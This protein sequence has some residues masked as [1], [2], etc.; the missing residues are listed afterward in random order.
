[1]DALPT[2]ILIAIYFWIPISALVG[3]ICWLLWKVLR[4]GLRRG[5]NDEPAAEEV[6][7][8]GFFGLRDGLLWRSNRPHI[9]SK[10]PL[11]EEL[12]P[13]PYSWGWWFQPWLWLLIV[14]ICAVIGWPISCDPVLPPLTDPVRPPVSAPPSR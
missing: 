7:R 11:V 3:G 2:Y 9:P 1:M 13:E 14:V 8:G 6:V 5:L 10:M 12:Q 4:V